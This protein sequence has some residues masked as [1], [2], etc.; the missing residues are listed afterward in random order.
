[1]Q[2]SVVCREDIYVLVGYAA[3]WSVDNQS[4]EE[5]EAASQLLRMALEKAK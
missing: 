3:N 5:E 1:M 2:C 4:S